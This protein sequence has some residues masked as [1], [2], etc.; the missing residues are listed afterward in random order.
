M[1]LRHPTGISKKDHDPLLA[2]MVKKGIPLTRKNYL[3]LAYPD[4]MPEWTPEL[5][6]ELPL[7]LQL[8]TQAA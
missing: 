1:A 2:Y 4:N 6:A 8:K 5:E 7:Q 3:D